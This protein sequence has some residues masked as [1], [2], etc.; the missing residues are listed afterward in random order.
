[1]SRAIDAEW[2]I[3]RLQAKNPPN[4]CMK[5]M[6]DECIAEIQTAPTI[7][8][9]S[10]EDIIKDIT[11]ASFTGGDGM[12]YVETLVALNAIKKYRQNVYILAK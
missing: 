11:D 10:Y 7:K 8:L 2:V 12:D 3:K 4:D 5:I 1:M 9:G 6:L